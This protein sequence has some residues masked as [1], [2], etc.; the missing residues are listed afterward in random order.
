MRAAAPPPDLSGSFAAYIREKIEEGYFP[1][2]CELPPPERFMNAFKIDL[3]GIIKALVAL[4]A[5]GIVSLLPKCAPEVVRGPEGEPEPLFPAKDFRE[6]CAL[7]ETLEGKALEKAWLKIDVDRLEEIRRG[8][9][10]AAPNLRLIALHNAIHRQTMAV[11]ESRSLRRCVESVAVQLE[12]FAK[13][14]FDNLTPRKA[15]VQLKAFDALLKALRDD[16][17]LLAK[18]LLAES[19]GQLR[20]DALSLLPEEA[21][22]LAGKHKTP[23]AA[24]A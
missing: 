13:M 21:V 20:D 19:L 3:A 1:K 10:G 17:L 7:F 23:R 9:E 2:G 11:C 12:F 18:G 16:D 5:D 24:R 4:E 15:G 6:L 8:L 22:L 14:S